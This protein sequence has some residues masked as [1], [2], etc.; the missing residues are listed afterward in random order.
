MAKKTK[1]SNLS[2]EERLEQALI[3]NWD[4]PYKLPPNWCWTKFDIVAKWGSG[5][6]PSR[7]NPEYYVGNIPWVKTGE[8]NNSFI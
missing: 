3:P 6:T 4:E 8:L 5:G 1:D 7:K 2:L